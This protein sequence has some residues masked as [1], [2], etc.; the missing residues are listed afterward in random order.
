MV[1]RDT[2][3]KLAHIGQITDPHFMIEVFQGRYS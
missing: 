3:G 1:A 2:K